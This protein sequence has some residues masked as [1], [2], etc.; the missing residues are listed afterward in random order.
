MHFHK[1]I[2]KNTPIHKNCKDLSTKAK[3]KKYKFN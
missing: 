3:T 2:T 1:S